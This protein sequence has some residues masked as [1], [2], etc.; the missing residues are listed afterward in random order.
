MTPLVIVVAS[1][2][3]SFLTF[4]AE[5]SH[6]FS[7]WLVQAKAATDGLSPYGTFVDIKPP[8]LIFTTSLWIAVF[9]T[10]DASMFFLQFSLTLASVLGVHK[11]AGLYTRFP[12]RWSALL[13]TLI[14]L[15]GSYSTMPLS[16]ELFG[17]PFI[18]WGAW[19]L[20]GKGAANNGPIFGSL[21]FGAAAT[22]KEAFLPVIAVPVILAI[23]SKDRIKT[24]VVVALT[25]ALQLLPYFVLMIFGWL[26]DYLTILEMKRSLFLYDFSSMLLSTLRLGFTFFTDVGIL[27]LVLVALVVFKI[28]RSARDSP[29]T[30]ALP[31]IHVPTLLT[32]SILFGLLLQQKPAV[33]HYAL[34]VIFSIWLLS[35]SMWRN[36]SSQ[37]GHKLVASLLLI[38]GISFPMHALSTISGD[39]LTI[40]SGAFFWNIGEAE[41]ISN[42]LSKGSNSAACLHVLDGWKSGAYYFYS[43]LR[44]CSPHFLAGLTSKSIDWSN[45]LNLDLE[46]KSSSVV[47]LKESS[48][49]DLDLTDY[50]KRIPM[51]ANLMEFSAV[52]LN[53]AKVYF[54]SEYLAQQFE[55]AQNRPKLQKPK[56]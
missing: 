40:R 51:F 2:L 56:T 4:E 17:L 18:V 55:V 36:E 47:L 50:K 45:E 32:L 37:G 10:S 34:L 5:V 24:W 19:F 29:D 43:G 9:Q 38:P 52:T 21:L 8:G 39:A 49:S 44:P 13:L 16:P 30:V 12:G 23:L 6:D 46:A 20:I 41:A 7:S 31:V 42:Y 22:F 1:A 54:G 53:G 25:G 3:L 33:G 15:G 48:A 26:N 35:I 27:A 11:L 28:R 14:Y